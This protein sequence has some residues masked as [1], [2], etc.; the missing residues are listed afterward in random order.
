MGTDLPGSLCWGAE[1]FLSATANAA[2]C[3]M[4]LSCLFPG[5]EPVSQGCAAWKGAWNDRGD[6]ERRP[7]RGSACVQASLGAFPLQLR[8]LPHCPVTLWRLAPSQPGLSSSR[9]Q[10]WHR[11][12]GQRIYPG[13]DCPFEVIWSQVMLLSC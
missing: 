2:L 5:R 7:Q 8:K 1:L 4:V 11:G 12:W 6:T 10:T 9:V 3:G 13:G